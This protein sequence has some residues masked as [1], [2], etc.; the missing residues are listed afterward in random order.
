[1]KKY[2][3]EII[4]VILLILSGTFHFAQSNDNGDGKFNNNALLDTDVAD[5]QI[6]RVGD[7]FFV[8]GYRCS[9]IVLDEFDKI[10]QLISST[11]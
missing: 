8:N 4:A 5:P 9:R 1:M 3:S 2:L 7:V 10:S 11:R 6:I